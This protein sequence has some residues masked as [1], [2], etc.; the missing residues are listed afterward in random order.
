MQLYLMQ[1]GLALSEQEDA[2]RPL[3]PG[4]VEQIQDAAAGMKQLR[5]AFDLIISSPKRRAHQTAALVAEAVRYPYSDILVSDSLLPQADPKDIL[6]L[7]VVEPSQSHILI[8]G[9]QP[10]LGKFASLLLG[11]GG[12]TIE[13]A[14][15]SAFAYDKEKAFSTL[16][17]LLTA[18]QLAR[19]RPGRAS[20]F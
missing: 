13:N 20:D 16:N 3:S 18:D 1:H 11:G 15:L 4:G 12:V 9:H 6:E 8:V 14:G 7:L 19:F 17:F 2:E 5:L 10:C